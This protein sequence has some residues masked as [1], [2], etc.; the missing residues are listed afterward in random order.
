MLC[1]S[2]GLSWEEGEHILHLLG[3]LPAFL[4]KEGCRTRHP[5]AACVSSWA[6]QL[7]QNAPPANSIRTLARDVYVCGGSNTGVMGQSV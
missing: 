7:R 5:Q 3:L 2:A 4:A 1:R 6:L